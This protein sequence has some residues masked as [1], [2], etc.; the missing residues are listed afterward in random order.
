M[1]ATFL[2]AILCRRWNHSVAASLVDVRGSIGWAFPSCFCCCC[3]LYKW[4]SCSQ[5]H[6]P[7]YR[8]ISPEARTDSLFW[9]LQPTCLQTWVHLSKQYWLNVSLNLNVFF[10]N[11]FP[12]LCSS[13][14]RVQDPDWQGQ[15]LHEGAVLRRERT[16]SVWP[17]E[18]D[19]RA[20]WG[21][22][23]V[24]FFFFS[25]TWKVLYK[26]IA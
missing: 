7:P 8:Q 1:S 2:L 19:A 9:R 18:E 23:M 21:T 11:C 10:S 24:W 26:F 13:A 12:F 4:C 6:I 15:G 14:Q 22:G 17:S 3:K 20:M 16:G 25:L 5:L